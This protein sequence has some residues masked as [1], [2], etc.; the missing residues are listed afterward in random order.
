MTAIPSTG[1]VL[2]SN[3]PK[4]G[5]VFPVQMMARLTGVSRSGFYAW[6]HRT[7]SDWA[8]ADAAL[9]ARIAEIHTASKQTY[10]APRSHAELADEGIGVG[11]RRV[12][13][14]MKAATL[15]GVSRCKGTRTTFGDDRVRPANDLVDRNFRADEPNQLWVADITYVP[16]WAGFIYLSVV[17]GAFSRRIVGWSMGHDLKAQLVIDAMS[18][19]IGQ[20]WPANVIHHSDQGSRGGFD[21]LSQC[22]ARGGFAMA[23]RG[24]ASGWRLRAWLRS[25]G[26]PGVAELEDRRL[27]WRA[28]AAGRSSEDAAVDAG[29]PRPVGSRWFREA[30]GMPP[31]HP[32]RGAPPPSGRYL[33]FAEREEIALL[34]AKGRG[35]REIARRIGRA[36]STVSRELRR[37]AATRS[38]G[39]EY[40]ATTG[41]VACRT[42]VAT[43]EGGE[44]GNERHSAPIRGRSPFRP[45]HSSRRQ[46]D[47]NLAYDLE[48]APPWPG[49]DAAVGTGLEPRAGLG[50]AEGRRPPGRDDAH[51][52][53]SHLPVPLRPGPWGAEARADRLP[54]DGTGSAR[55]SGTR[56]GAS[57]V[58]RPAKGHDQRAACRSGRSRIDGIDG[59]AA[60]QLVARSA[61]RLGGRARPRSTDGRE[62][63][64]DRLPHSNP[65]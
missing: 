59:E 54:A 46:A 28:I 40:R 3:V 57:Q 29:I 12:E 5:A 39:S 22:F 61:A 4:G 36:A 15:A 44:A 24:E 26:R 9:S 55:P 14:L 56:P 42:R 10:G 41:A 27:F 25:P 60:T 32:A 35:V 19:A 16:T 18:M 11:R 49:P 63:V 23:G 52:S 2:H 17:L 47:H 33:S 65:A 45:R 20:R 6:Q 1:R 48:E 64:L 30:G 51:Q 31:T 50:E 37:N 58:L 53:R 7:P 43:P 62:A 34:R 8:V 13:R 38:G 21:R